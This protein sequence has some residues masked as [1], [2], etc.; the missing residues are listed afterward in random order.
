MVGLE[1]QCFFKLKLCLLQKPKAQGLLLCLERSMEKRYELFLTTS[2]NF[3][4][5][6]SEI[7]LHTI[8]VK[9]YFGSFF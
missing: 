4:N 9:G 3:D 1:M 7:T 2:T 8:S 5:G 6:I